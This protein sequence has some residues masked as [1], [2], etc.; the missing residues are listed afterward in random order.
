MK[1]S[2]KLHNEPFQLIKNGTKTIEIRLYDEKRQLLNPGDIIEFQ[3]RITKETIEVKILKLHLYP[4]FIELYKHFDK[5]S[6]G[7]SENEE[8]NPDDMNQYYSKEEQE[9]YGVVAIEIELIKK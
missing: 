3:N 6:L 1:H 8:A 7:Y 5:I 2:M 9:K 4:N